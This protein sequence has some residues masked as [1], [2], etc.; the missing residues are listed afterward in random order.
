[1][2]LFGDIPKHNS[3][4]FGQRPQE[5]VFGALAAG[6]LASLGAGG[7]AAAGGAGGAAGLASLFG[8]GGGGASGQGTVQ[9]L[10]Q[11]LQKLGASGQFSKGGLTVGADFG[12]QGRQQRLMDALGSIGGSGVGGTAEGG[13]LGGVPVRTL[14]AGGD[15]ANFASLLSVPPVQTQGQQRQGV[16][17]GQPIGQL[18]RFFGTGRQPRRNP[19]EG[20][21]SVR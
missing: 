3:R 9:A 16:Q 13:G 4:I 12:E 7:A 17:P 18:S 5:F 10:M 1:M 2:T 14:G 19:G 21:F 20:R 6:G 8:G 11:I 15:G